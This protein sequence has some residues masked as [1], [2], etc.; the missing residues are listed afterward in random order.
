MSRLRT[1][2]GWNDGKR[3]VMSPK[4]TG[5]AKKRVSSRYL[6]T[7]TRYGEMSAVRRLRSAQSLTRAM[8]CSGC[9]A[10]A[11]SSR[12]SCGVASS[13]SSMICSSVMCVQSSHARSKSSCTISAAVTEP[14][15]VPVTMSNGMPSSRIAFHAP[16]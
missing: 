14:M 12:F 5:E 8:S 4:S 7:S 2:T 10:S 16:T 3:A 13:R 1:S 9:S 15:D 6:C 11:A